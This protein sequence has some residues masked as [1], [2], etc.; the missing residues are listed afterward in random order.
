MFFSSTFRFDF[1]VDREQFVILL[2]LCRS[3][4]NSLGP[5]ILRLASLRDYI[6]ASHFV[7]T[8][9]TLHILPRQGEKWVETPTFRTML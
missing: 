1:K 6:A 3:A 4:L 2:M 7:F 9:G 5:E 8:G